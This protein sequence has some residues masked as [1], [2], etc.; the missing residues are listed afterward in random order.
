MCHEVPLKMCKSPF[1]PKGLATTVSAYGVDC[2]YDLLL[3]Y[4]TI[5][6]WGILPS[7]CEPSQSDTDDALEPYVPEPEPLQAY[8]LSSD[9]IPTHDRILAAYAHCF[10]VR[11]GFSALE[12]YDL[13][14]KEDRVVATRSNYV[15]Y[16]KQGLF[17]DHVNELLAKKYIEASFSPYS[18]P[19]L[20]VP[21]GKDKTRMLVDFRRIN[22]L[23]APFDYPI[24]EV[25][26]CLTRLAGAKVFATLDLSKGYH[27]SH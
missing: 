12:P 24:P 4:Q 10:D 2:D 9:H 27:P 16:Q 6:E 25:N 23:T 20:L 19:A 1:T 8:A 13:V 15:P 7:L 5:V 26:T 14:L 17:D 3:S 22:D 18:S 11:E 21:K